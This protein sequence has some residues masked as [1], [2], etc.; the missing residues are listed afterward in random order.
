MPKTLLALLL[1]SVHMTS[2][3]HADNVDLALEAFHGTCLAHGP[4]FERTV[5]AAGKLGWTP[6]PGDDFASVGSVNAIQ[7]WVASGN[8]MP[9]KTMI[10]VAKA[11]LNGKAVQICSITL[12]DIDS[13]AFEARFFA[14]TD[15]VKIG[16]ERNPTQVSKLFILI[17]G[18]R[19]QLVHLTRPRSR[20][21]SN[22]IIAS[23]I[24]DD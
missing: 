2:P 23:S 10:A 3:V 17:A 14:R 8:D 7:G 24:A 12:F 16:E 6:R 20:I 15:A 18:N 19:K 4:D 5:A 22:M 13:A 1:T 11:T 9:A 21:T